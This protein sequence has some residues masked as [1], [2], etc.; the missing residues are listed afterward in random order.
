[1]DIIRLEK[2]CCLVN[3]WNF[4]KEHFDR[5]P[6]TV[7]KCCSDLT[8]TDSSMGI[9]CNLGNEILEIVESVFV[10]TLQHLET[11]GGVLSHWCSK[12][13][14]WKILQIHKKTKFFQF[15]DA[16]NMII[17]IYQWDIKGTLM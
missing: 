5:T 11:V 9:F 3:L 14:L 1:M 2:L 17:W 13:L 15:D 16:H 6:P 7:S 8:N 12:T 4:S 10:K